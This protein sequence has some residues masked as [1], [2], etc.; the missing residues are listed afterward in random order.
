MRTL[1]LTLTIIAVT[2]G[3]LM[4]I[5]PFGSLAVLPGVFS[6]ITAAL[7]YYLSKKQEKNKVF[8]LGLLAISILIIVVSS[9]KFLWV[10]DEVATDQKFEQKEEESKEE[11]IDE[12][13]EIENELEDLE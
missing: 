11:S 5:L 4:A 7:A 13:K 3:T 8:P 6:L 12:L 9:T 2:I 10:K 1:F